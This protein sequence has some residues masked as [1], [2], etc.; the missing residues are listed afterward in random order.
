MVLPGAT[1]FTTVGRFEIELDQYGIPHGQFVYCRHYLE[2]P[3]AAPIDPN[4]LGGLSDT[5]YRTTKFD[6]VFSSLRDA[7][8]RGWSRNIIQ[9]TAPSKLRGRVDYMLQSPDDRLGAL[10]FGRTLEPPAPRR[11]FHKISDLEN[12]AVL[13]E[14]IILK[15]QSLEEHDFERIR[16]LTLFRTSICGA[17]PKAV[18]EDTERIWLAK[19]NHIR[20][21]WNYAR[22]EHAMMELAKSCDIHCGRSCVATVAGRDVL[23]LERFDRERTDEGYLRFRTISGFTVCTGRVPENKEGRPCASYMMLAEE[24]RK[25]V[26]EPVDDSKE[27][28][29]RMVFNSLIANN[30][31]GLGN[32]SFV[33]KDAG[34]KLSPVYDLGPRAKLFGLERRGLSMDCGIYGVQADKRNLLSECGR[35]CLCKEEAAAI[36]DAM[37]ERVRNSWYRVARSTGV[38]EKD[39]ATI[40]AAFAYPGFRHDP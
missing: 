36:I 30:N 6:G 21:K 8:P 3:D 29:R 24:L 11:N 1:H 19:F 38:S 26:A 23:L 32:H 7:V 9:Q 12:L 27:L 5:V 22:V 28:Y 35:F 14:T 20:D 37:E 25:I 10:G 2:N 15:H 13:A 4:Q 31:D 40:S 34:W 33:A 18:V 16:N 39:C 17:R